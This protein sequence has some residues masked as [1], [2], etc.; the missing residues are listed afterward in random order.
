MLIFW[1]ELKKINLI[2]K[3]TT[4][5]MDQV[6]GNANITELLVK[7]I[8]HYITVLKHLKWNIVN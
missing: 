2:T 7:N 8:K 5:F 4:E 3:C 1:K 6:N